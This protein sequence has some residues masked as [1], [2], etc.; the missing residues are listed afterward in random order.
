MSDVQSFI[1]CCETEFGTTIM[2][3]EAASIKQHVAAGD[4]ILNVGGGIGSLEERF[5]TYEIIG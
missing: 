5:P 4:R 2:D 3:R 1:R